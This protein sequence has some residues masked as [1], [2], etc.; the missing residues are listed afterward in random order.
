[1]TL[2]I[3][4]TQIFKTTMTYDF[5]I[6]YVLIPFLFNINYKIQE[7]AIESISKLP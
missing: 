4:E 6:R 3:A 5:I 2:K 1:M 7:K